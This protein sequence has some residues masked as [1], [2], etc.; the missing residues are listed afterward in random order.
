MSLAARAGW[1]GPAPV[2]TR[3]A[4]A[5]SGG[6]PDRPEPDRP[7]QPGSKYHLRT[8]RRGIPLAVGLSAANTHDSVLLE[9]MV[10]AVPRGQRPARPARAAPQ[11][12]G[13]ATRGP[14][15]GAGVA[16]CRL[17]QTPGI[18]PPKRQPHGLLMR[19]GVGWLLRPADAGR[20]DLGPPSLGGP[21]PDRRAR[22]AAGAATSR[23]AH[24]PGSQSKGS[25]VGLARGRLGGSVLL[26][27]DAP[28]P[29]GA[30][31]PDR[32]PRAILC[33]AC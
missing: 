20:R 33:L 2:S 13:Q 3:S 8:D 16:C 26:G 24:Q 23:L 27:S 5:P 7:R 22:R 19:S 11:A 30:V 1:T 10:D 17:G 6:L 12:S 21:V 15:P 28:T 18:P 14:G 9:L 29:R 31:G 25:L 4:C 32:H